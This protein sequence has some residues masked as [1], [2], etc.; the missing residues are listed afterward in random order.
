MLITKVELGET[1]T[2]KP[3]VEMYGNNGRL[4]YPELR[5]FEL[6]EL[7]VVGVDPNSLD[8]GEVRYARFWAYY[9]ES[10]KLNQHGNPYRDVVRLEPLESVPIG[11]TAFDGEMNSAILAEVQAIK[12]QIGELCRMFEL[13]FFAG[14]LERP[15]Q[16]AEPEAIPEPPP[17][18]EEPEATSPAPEPETDRATPPPL[19]EGQAKRQFSRLAGPAIRDGKIDASAVNELTSAISAGATNWRDALQQ[20]REKVAEKVAA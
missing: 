1:E 18:F 14:S 17:E 8:D 9:T 2:G 3:V 7:S 16:A 6:S 20:L 11:P 15:L 12:Q 13:A 4:K 19:D 10:D 5:L